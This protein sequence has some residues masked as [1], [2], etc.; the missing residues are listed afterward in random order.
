M[1]NEALAQALIGQL[2][3][4]TNYKINI[5]NE[6]G[7]VIA[8]SDKNRIGTFHE[9]AYEMIQDEQDLVEVTGE[10]GYIGVKSGINM[11]LQFK[12]KTIG[13]I[14]I[15]GD[16]ESIRPIALVIRKSVELMIECESNKIAM[17]HK[18]N[19]KA[20]MLNYLMYADIDH[21][22]LNNVK[23]LCK[24]L[25]YREDLPRIPI[26]F[27]TCQKIDSDLL[28]KYFK[29]TV[30]T[31]T[32]DIITTDE[33]G[34]VILFFSYL[35]D[36]YGFFCNYKYVINEYLTN[37]LTCLKSNK[38][39]LRMSVG[40]METSWINYKF[41]YEKALWVHENIKANESG[42]IYFYEHVDEYLKSK[43]PLIE[44]HKIFD[45]FSDKLSDQFV[46]T[47]VKHI[48]VLYENNYSFQKSSNELF[49]H[50]NT[51]A[52]R[53]DKIRGQL[54]VDPIQNM[55]DR[56]LMEYLYYY[57]SHIQSSPILEN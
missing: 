6:S 54:G 27:S 35:E 34:N 41:A 46:E 38:L 52:F 44:L 12:N 31:N 4:C 28:L 16:I 48:G 24:S 11:A 22:G 18:R 40:P 3:Q 9:V 29:E 10:D 36:L 19:A 15:T 45:V 56:E 47:F 7:T 23:N 42:D 30:R 8:S 43:L 1:L 51:L 2:S 25:G 14:G 13:V 20:Q 39:G 17:T 55:K 26:I 50:K 49:I 21:Q 33:K 32:Q 5:M 37:F 53:M 57:L